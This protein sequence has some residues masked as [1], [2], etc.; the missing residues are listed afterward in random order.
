MSPMKSQAQR[1][2]LHAK[3]PEIAE[4]FE[5]ETPKGRKL[6]RHVK[7]RAPKPKRK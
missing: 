1:A 2:Y 5:A 6:P 4:R 7:K 3:H